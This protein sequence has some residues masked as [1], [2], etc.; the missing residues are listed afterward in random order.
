MEHLFADVPEAIANTVELSSRLEFTLGDLGYEFPRYPVPEGETIN[1]IK[2]PGGA[3]PFETLAAFSPDASLILTAGAPEGRLQLW[4][5][6]SEAN[7]GFEVRQYVTAKLPP[8]LRDRIRLW[9]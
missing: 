4:R 6:P 8:A 1:T 5:A 3:T 9:V 7:R 2:N